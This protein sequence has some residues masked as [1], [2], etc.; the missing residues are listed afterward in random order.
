MIAALAVLALP[1]IVYRA[2]ALQPEALTP[3][4]RLVRVVTAPVES[5]LVGSISGLSTAWHSYVDVLGARKQAARSRSR[6]QVLE[7]QLVEME[8]LRREVKALRELLQMRQ[9]NPEADMVAAQVVAAGVGP[10]AQT[11][12]IDRGS[13]HGIRRGLPVVSPAG[14]VGIVQRVGWNASEVVLITDDR[15]SLIAESATTGARGRVRGQ[16]GFRVRLEDVLQTDG[17]LPDEAWVTGG[18]GDGVPSGIPIG[19]VQS[20]EMDPE[21]PVLHADLKP[22]ASLR[23]LRRVSVLLTPERVPELH[24]P[25]ALQPSALWHSAME[26]P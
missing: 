23:R 4:D 14:L 10:G 18:L 24:T 1:W 12:E 7:R 16:G 2:H 26:G 17:V 8:S 19:V 22:A 20:V 15:V 6:V 13:L 5:L 3:F 25:D 21:R 9:L 11:L